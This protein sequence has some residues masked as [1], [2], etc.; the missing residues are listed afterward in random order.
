MKRM[1]RACALVAWGARPFNLPERGMVLNEVLTG[2]ARWSLRLLVV[3]MGVLLFLSL[4]AAG[5]VLALA[6]G[7]RRPWSRP[8]GRPGPPWARVDPRG[9]WSTATRSTAR[10]TAHAAGTARAGGARLREAADVTDVQV[11]EIH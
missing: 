3:A 11:R 8:A 2:L 1:G 4:L 6:W 5:C 9:A 10:W 7:V